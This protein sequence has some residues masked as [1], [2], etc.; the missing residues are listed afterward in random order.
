MDYDSVYP[1]GCLWARNFPKPHKSHNGSG[2]GGPEA[3]GTALRITN[4]ADLLNRHLEHGLDHHLGNS[5]ALLNGENLLA[6]V[7]QN[8]T[9][10]APVAAV[11]GAGGIE[12]GNGML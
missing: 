4:F 6:M 7:D 1:N 12:H 2:A 11:D 8:N 9:D 3:V 5:H 10:F